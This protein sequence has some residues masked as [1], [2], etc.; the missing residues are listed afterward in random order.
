MMMKLR[1]FEQA[2]LDVLEWRK[3]CCELMCK[4]TSS[5]CYTSLVVH[6]AD[7]SKL[8]L[9]QAVLKAASNMTD[10][11]SN[12]LIYLPMRELVYT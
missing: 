2:L 1:V 9:L 4:F 10:E 6:T 5:Y 7:L 3:T 11:A 12:I 8:N